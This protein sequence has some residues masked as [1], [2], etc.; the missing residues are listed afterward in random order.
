MLYVDDMLKKS[1]GKITK[2]T[3]SGK[4]AKITYF[5]PSISLPKYSLGDTVQLV[6]F[7][8]LE[9]SFIL[10]FLAGLLLM[11]MMHRFLRGFKR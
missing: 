1:G 8:L 5:S 4:V 10:C 7:G 11:G 3:R 6:T 9:L 2:S